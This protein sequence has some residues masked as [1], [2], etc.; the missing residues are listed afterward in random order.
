LPS[1][2]FGGNRAPFYRLR[3]P[4]T[5]DYFLTA[6]VGERD[7]AQAV[8][9]YVLEG[10][11]G[12]VS[13]VPG[14]GL[15]PLYRLFNPSTGR[16]FYTG[17]GY[18]YYTFTYP[19]VREGIACYLGFAFPQFL[20]SLS[21]PS[22]RYVLTQFESERDSLRA[23]GWQLRESPGYVWPNEEDHYVRRSGA[24]NPPHPAPFYRLFD[25]ISGDHLYTLSEEERHFAELFGY[26]LE[27]V[28]GYAYPAS[29]N[30]YGANVPLYRAYNPQ[31]GQHFYTRSLMEYNDLPGL[32]FAQEGIAAYLFPPF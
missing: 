14:D 28:A 10:S 15:K 12:D 31:T 3:H 11:I 18:Q 6:L 22:G 1:F 26:I 27:G 4:A 25:P 7:A 17:S 13:T 5:G 23:N 21:H 29:N 2:P 30:Y 19:W 8:F 24:Q 32:G 16:H 20:Y 9:G